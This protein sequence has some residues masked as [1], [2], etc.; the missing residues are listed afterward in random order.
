MIKG[1][2]RLGH[3]SDKALY[4]DIRPSR[5]PDNNFSQYVD[6]H[7]VQCSSNLVLVG[8]AVP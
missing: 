8:V 6:N 1:L 3:C 2:T 5:Y 4:P 7:P